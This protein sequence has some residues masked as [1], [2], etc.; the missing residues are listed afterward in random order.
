MLIADTSVSGDDARRVQKTKNAAMETSNEAPAAP[1]SHC[2][3]SLTW[4][5]WRGGCT[6]SHS[7]HGRE[8]PQ[9]L[10]YFVLRRGRVGRCQVCKTQHIFSNRHGDR[11]IVRSSAQPTQKGPPKAVLSAI[12]GR[13]RTEPYRTQI[14]RICVRQ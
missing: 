1:A 7:E 10:W 13:H 11:K 2:C 12:I 9:R 5:L 6:R 14:Q 3:A 4:W 8:M